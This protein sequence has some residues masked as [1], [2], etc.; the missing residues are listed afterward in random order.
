MESLTTLAARLA[1]Q[2]RAAAVAGDDGQMAR[3]LKQLLR[4]RGP[5]N[6]QQTAL[7]VTVLLQLVH[8]LRAACLTDEMTGLPNRRGFVQFGTRF[9]D[10][11]ARDRRP[12]YLVYLELNHLALVN[13]TS[14]RTVGDALLRQMGNF[15]RDLF[16][17]YGVHEVLGRLGGN[18]FAALTTSAE[19]AA[20]SAIMLRARRTPAP[21]GALPRGQPPL[22]LSVG[23]A[24][25]DPQ[26]PVLLDELL[27]RS[28]QAMQEHKRSG[29]NA[30][31]ESDLA[32]GPTRL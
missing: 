19:H 16:P 22:S 31:P 26:R 20:R 24:V 9:L 13:D 17:G 5:T 12:A 1:N 10:V 32:I 29:R 3:L 30:S 27:E 6:G 25:F 21:G 4:L 2:L 11:A 7:Q 28:E 18:E 14:G 15:M 8:S 23:V